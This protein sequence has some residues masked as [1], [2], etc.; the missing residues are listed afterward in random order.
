MLLMQWDFARIRLPLG[1]STRGL[2][3]AR[4]IGGMRRSAFPVNTARGGIIDEPALKA[5]LVEGH[6][7]GA[8]LD[9]FEIE[10][11]LD[12]ELFLLPNFIGT[13]HIGGSTEGA[14]LAMGPAAITSL[15][16]PARPITDRVL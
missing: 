15:G 12:R 11:P 8:A 6:I 9:V 2:I 5:A 16:D 3:G 14:L 7:A 1:A 4:E 10:P 13:P